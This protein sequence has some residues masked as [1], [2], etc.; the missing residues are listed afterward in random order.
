MLRG[1]KEKWYG[2]DELPDLLP[3]FC[4]SQ[5]LLLISGSTAGRLRPERFAPGYPDGTNILID[6]LH[7]TMG[8]EISARSAVVAMA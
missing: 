2:C 4:I 6:Q 8:A 3:A 5:G 1:L 7:A